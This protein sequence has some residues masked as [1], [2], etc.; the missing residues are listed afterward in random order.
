MSGREFSYP[1]M[2]FDKIKVM[3]MINL[4]IHMKSMN[5]VHHLKWG[6]GASHCNRSLTNVC[7]Y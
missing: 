5:G 1:L 4:I 2:V 6:F 3:M 7:H